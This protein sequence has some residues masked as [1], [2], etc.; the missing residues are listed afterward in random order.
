[1][2]S[3]QQ[4]QLRRKRDTYR[5]SKTLAALPASLPARSATHQLY[6]QQ[7]ELASASA[8]SQ[9]QPVLA[10]SLSRTSRSSVSS[11]SVEPSTA[12]TSASSAS[13]RGGGAHLLGR[14]PSS[15]S[16]LL[17]RVRELIREKVV[18]TTV[19]RSVLAAM[20]RERRQRAAD[21]FVEALR[22]HQQQQQHQQHRESSGSVDATTAIITPPCAL[23]VSSSTR[24]TGP[25]RYRTRS[26]P[27]STSRGG[28]R[29]YSPGPETLSS[30]IPLHS[31]GASADVAKSAFRE[32]R[33]TSEDTSSRRHR[34]TT[35]FGTVRRLSHDVAIGYR[36]KGYGRYHIGP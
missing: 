1:M 21:A 22:R 2:Q 28:Q 17:S 33:S 5:R 10:R 12:R 4:L 18:E 20:E 9:S 7:P 14:T 24:R 3:V 13:H 25:R 32:H 36:S 15:P 23:S 35:A 29:R 31:I 11:A 8:P 34:T 19:D 16:V 30:D 26:D 27:A 6:H